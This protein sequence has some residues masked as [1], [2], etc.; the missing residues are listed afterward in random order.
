M[1]S[2]SHS[3]TVKLGR[4]C[5]AGRE[6][7]VFC[8]TVS[9]DTSILIIFDHRMGTQLLCSRFADLLTLCLCRSSSIQR[10]SGCWICF[11]S[12]DWLWV[13]DYCPKGNWR[14]THKIAGSQT[15]IQPRNRPV[16]ENS[17]SNNSRGCPIH[18]IH[19]FSG[20]VMRNQSCQEK[21]RYMNTLGI[22]N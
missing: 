11:E 20:T 14:W 13:V 5:I 19:W 6:I 16:H 17:K 3:R 10:E 4:N 9:L 21:I 15:E 7:H 18:S 12:C 8:V 2:R 1:S 22:L